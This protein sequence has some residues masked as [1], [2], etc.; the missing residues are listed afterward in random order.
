MIRISNI[1][2]RN[3]GDPSSYENGVM[4]PP[5]LRKSLMPIC[6]KALKIKEKD[7]ARLE[8]FRHS[9]D[10]RKKPDI[11]DVYTIDVTLNVDEKKAIQKS[12][13][14][15]AQIFE[16]VVYDFPTYGSKEMLQRPVVVGA[17]PCGLFAAY[18]LSIHGFKPILI[19]RGRAVEDRQKDVENF[20]KSGVLDTTS[21][22]QFGEGGAGAFS[23]GKLNT[24]VRDKD[25]IG[26]AALRIFIQHGAPEEIYYEAKPHIGTDKLVDVVRNIREDIKRLGGTVLFETQMT[27]IVFENTDDN[28][29]QITG[30][31]VKD[32][33]SKESVIETDTVIMAIGHSARDTFEMLFEQGVYMEAKAFAVGLRVEHS[34]KKINK[35]QYGVK[36]S[37]TLPASAY[38]VV[39][40]TSSGRGV[41]SFCMCPG[42]YVVNASSC[43]GQL[44]V[45]GMSYYARDSKNANSAIIVTVKPEDFEADGPLGGVEFQRELEKKAYELGQ[46]RVPVE[47][48]KDFKNNSCAKANIE[49]RAGWNIPCIKGDYTFANVHELL[50]GYIK[51]A[52][53]EGMTAF[54]RMIEGF[55]DDDTLMEGIESRTSSPVRITRGENL[56]SVSVKGLYPCGEGAG[57]AGG[58]MSAAMDGMKIAAIIGAQ[59]CPGI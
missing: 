7:I 9:V 12:R 53:D 4:R 56:Q 38:K 54:G 51:E 18:E 29:K 43:E 17:G 35:A 34:Q 30:I 24:M 58:I 46:G 48:L 10:A 1:K 37:K 27:G 15:N 59:R 40:N 55:D 13:N 32:K 5:A 57:Y 22:V 49:D 6:A 31:K 11:F 36:E 41:Y 45:N 50:P 44:C 28:C 47:Y 21:N 33:S 42:G 25:G 20:W 19:E 39:H 52:I 3:E 8:V 2:V 16:P 26:R 23:D 14:K